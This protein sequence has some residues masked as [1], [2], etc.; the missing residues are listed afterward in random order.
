VNSPKSAPKPVKS[1]ACRKCKSEIDAH[2]EICPYC[3]TRNPVQ[4]GVGAVISAVLA[5]GFFIWL[6][7]PGTKG[8]DAKPA[9]GNS[10]AAAI[11][12]T[13][14]SSPVSQSSSVPEKPDVGEMVE[15][16]KLEKEL[17]AS[18]PRTLAMF[19]SHGYKNGVAGIM[20]AASLLAVPGSEQAWCAGRSIGNEKAGCYVVFYY[21]KERNVTPK[22]WATNPGCGM[23]ARWYARWDDLN[24]YVPDSVGAKWLSKGNAN[25]LSH[26]VDEDWRMCNEK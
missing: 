12:Q 21:T 25:V 22:L 23:V 6:I 1:A 3:R 14:E 8:D 16:Q 10:M 11:P 5:I 26:L 18:S 24:H 4:S 17:R 20:H 7:W 19:P 13:S 15:N 9:T 2:A